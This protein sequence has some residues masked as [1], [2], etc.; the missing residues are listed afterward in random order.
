[1][2]M[3]EKA[4]AEARR[5]ARLRDAALVVLLERAGGSLEF[6][7]ADYQAVVDRYGGSTN[8]NLHFEVVKPSGQPERARLVLERKP[9][10]QGDL[11]V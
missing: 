11:P 4:A 5:S 6:T 8:F 2:S 10:A 9:P 1:M 3:D 7:E